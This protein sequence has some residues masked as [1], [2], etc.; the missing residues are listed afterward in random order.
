MG[1]ATARR[2][3]DAGAK[4]II[5][6]RRLDRLTDIAQDID[7][8]PVACDITDEASI[9]ALAE[10]ALAEFGCLDVAVNFAGIS[11]LASITQVTREDLQLMCDVHLIGTALFFKHM[12]LRMASGG[13]L[14]TTSSLTAV[15]APIEHAAYAGSKA[16]ADQIVRVAAGELGSRGIRVNSI[17][18]GFMR[19]EMTD[20]YFE[21]PGLEESFV[22]EVPLGRL[23]VVEDVAE[24]A[25]WLAS[26]ASRSTTGQRIDVTS[27]QSLRRTPTMDEIRT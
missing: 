13:S 23:G 10:R 21:V 15:V 1:I 22:R 17:V 4:L 16:G 27:G 12:S 2:F 14:I 5:A 6:S 9:A 11:T 8:I 3:A 19:S 24:A 7:A 26:D 18:P 20:Q 25:L